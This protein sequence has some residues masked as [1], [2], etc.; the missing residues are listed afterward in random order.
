MPTRRVKPRNERVAALLERALEQAEMTI[1]DLGRATG[2][3]RNAGALVRGEV[4]RPSPEQIAG[5][6]KWLPVTPEQ[7]LKA[8]GYDLYVRPSRE[9]PLEVVEA[10]NALPPDARKG[11][12]ALMQSAARIARGEG[13]VPVP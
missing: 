2:W 13:E 11:M 9:L 4:G 5:L 6:A 1:E 3:H 10:W 7:L 8:W 12:L